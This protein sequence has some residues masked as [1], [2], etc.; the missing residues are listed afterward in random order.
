MSASQERIPMLM[1]NDITI[2]PQPPHPSD[3]KFQNNKFYDGRSSSSGGTNGL[4]I[5]NY[6]INSKNGFVTRICCHMMKGVQKNIQKC[7]AA[8]VIISFF[9]IILLTQYMDSSSALVGWVLY[10]CF[11]QFSLWFSIK[12][13]L[14]WF[15]LLHWVIS[16]ATGRIQLNFTILHD[17]ECNWKFLS[18]LKCFFPLL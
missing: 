10:I 4:I 12:C 1:R 3:E 7:V 8:L 16:L 9:S 13:H 15:S 2:T 18:F 5:N 6:N 11:E 17:S 14:C